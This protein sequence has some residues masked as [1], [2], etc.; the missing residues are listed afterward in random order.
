MASVTKPISFRL[1]EHY[2][3]RLKKEADRYGM[4]PGDYARRLVLDA[5]ENVEEK[6]VEDSLQ[7]I[8]REIGELRTDFATSVLA[9]L[10]GAGQLDHEDAKDWVRE[11]LKT[12]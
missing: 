11:N 2:I 8:K 5:L 4:S 7:A 9:L 3:E 12:K 1:D 6:R 10:I